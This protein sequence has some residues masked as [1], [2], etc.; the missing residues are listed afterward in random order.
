[1]CV[2]HTND[3]TDKWTNL[4]LYRGSKYVATVT[5]RVEDDVYTDVVH[6]HKTGQVVNVICDHYYFNDIRYVVTKVIPSALP[7]C[8]LKIVPSLHDGYKRLVT[9]LNNACNIS[10]NRNNIGVLIAKQYPDSMHL[11]LL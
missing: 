2:I 1:M 8:V 5:V 3:S 4:S 9:I 6:Y 7:F 10:I 11:L